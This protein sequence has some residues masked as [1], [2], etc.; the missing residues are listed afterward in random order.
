MKEKDKEY[1]L[2]CLMQQGFKKEI[3]ICQTKVKKIKKY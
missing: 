3:F 2:L 1:Y